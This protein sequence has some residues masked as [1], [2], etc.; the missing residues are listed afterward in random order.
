MGINYNNHS[1]FWRF[2]PWKLKFQMFLDIEMGKTLFLDELRKF[3]RLS[4]QIDSKIS[5]RTPI[6]DDID[7]LTDYQ[8]DI[9]RMIKILKAKR[10]SIK[11]EIKEFRHISHILNSQLL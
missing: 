7:I 8:K 9:K 4:R 6:H 5:D 3:Q 1:F 11:K 10:K 2:L